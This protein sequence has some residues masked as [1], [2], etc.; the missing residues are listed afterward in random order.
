MD[1]IICVCQVSNSM[2]ANLIKAHL[3][4]E[5]IPCYLK[6]DDAGGAMPQLTYTNG[7]EIMVKENDRNEAMSII[8]GHL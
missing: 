4:S 8:Q 1:E 6:S 7:I 2:Q 5:G 3:E